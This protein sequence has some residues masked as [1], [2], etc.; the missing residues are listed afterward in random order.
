[1]PQY[2]I[3]IAPKTWDALQTKAKRIGT[4][5]DALIDV[6]VMEFVNACACEIRDERRNA[7]ISSVVNL[8]ADK[9]DEIERA[10]AK[11]NEK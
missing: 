9:L 6:R 4:T 7:V 10:I 2:K 3:E 1:M 8:P 11:L 5:P